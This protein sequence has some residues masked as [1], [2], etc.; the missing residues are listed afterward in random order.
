[1]FLEYNVIQFSLN[2]AYGNRKKAKQKLKNYLEKKLKTTSMGEKD[3][4]D[5]LPSSTNPSPPPEVKRRPSLMVVKSPAATEPLSN[6]TSVTDSGDVKVNGSDV[7]VEQNNTINSFNQTN[8]TETDDEIRVRDCRKAEAAGKAK[9][10]EKILARRLE[11]AHALLTT[12]STS[13]DAVK[14]RALD[15]QPEGD[16]VTATALPLTIRNRGSAA[17][18]E[19]VKE[20]SRSVE[21]NNQ[22]QSRQLH[23]GSFP[24]IT[25]EHLPMPKATPMLFPFISPS[26][27]SFLTPPLT[28]EQKQAVFSRNSRNF[29]VSPNQQHQSQEETGNSDQSGQEEPLEDGNDEEVISP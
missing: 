11:E 18:P 3:E 1:L 12:N 7:T 26:L 5:G 6:Q 28:E 17:R 14:A 25:P 22:F 2:A 23:V 16:S 21:N 13:E 19:S 4:S 9:V 15:D 24:D 20:V 8:L 29:E 10:A 27:L